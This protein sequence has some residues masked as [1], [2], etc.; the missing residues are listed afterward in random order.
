MK[1]L[2][3]VS[4]YPL[5]NEDRKNNILFLAAMQGA[6]D[7]VRGVI[8]VVCK[9]QTTGKF[10]IQMAICT[11]EGA[12]YINRNQAMAFFNLIPAPVIDHNLYNTGDEDIPDAIKDSNGEVVLN[13]CKVCGGAE[14]SLS[15]TCPQRKLSSYEL[16]LISQGQ[17]NF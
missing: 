15:R 1:I 6:P 2:E 11:E 17:L 16:D 12:I 9:D 10:D 5:T 13:L 8:S 4:S 7:D 3:E 14:S